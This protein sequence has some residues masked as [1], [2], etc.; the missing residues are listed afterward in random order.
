MSDHGL[1]AAFDAAKAVFTFCF[2]GE[3]VVEIEAAIEAGRELV[4]VEN[5]GADEGA[6][7][8]SLL[9]QELGP[10]DMLGRERDAEIGDAVHAGQQAGEDGGV[11][12]VGDGTVRKGLGKPDAVSGD[13]VDG[14]SLDVLVSVA[15]EVVGAECVDGD[16]EDVG[17]LSGGGGGRYRLRPEGGLRGRDREEACSKEASN[18]KDDGWARGNWFHLGQRITGASEVGA[19]G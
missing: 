15:A 4:A 8:V 1:G 18:K 7:L 13:G 17:L 9:F 14:G 6:G 12:S 16:E 10:G 3:V 2:R 11:R 19:L 5:Y